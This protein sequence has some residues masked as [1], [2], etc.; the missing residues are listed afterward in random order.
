MTPTVN[1]FGHRLNYTPG[2]AL[3]TLGID[4]YVL[5]GCG[6]AVAA[7]HDFKT[8]K[9]LRPPTSRAEVFACRLFLVRGRSV[10]KVV[11]RRMRY[12]GL[13]QRLGLWLRERDSA[14]SHVTFI[15]GSY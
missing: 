2:G 9:K 5:V 7:E 12:R 1:N 10:P 11:G 13:K 4:Y 6:V 3:C 8:Q 14:S 15:K